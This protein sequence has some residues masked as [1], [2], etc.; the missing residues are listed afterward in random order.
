MR[1]ARVRMLESE[2]ACTVEGINRLV[3]FNKALGGTGN[4]FLLFALLFTHLVFPPCQE[5]GCTLNPEATG[6]RF[7]L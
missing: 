1:L 2:T 3:W 7:Q 6:T 5:C 4:H